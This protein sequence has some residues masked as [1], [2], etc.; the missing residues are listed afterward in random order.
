[1]SWPLTGTALSK[2]NRLLSDLRQYGDFPFV[3]SP[4]DIT[5]LQEVIIAASDGALRPPLDDV[6]NRSHFWMLEL[7]RVLGEKV[8]VCPDC[9]PVI[10]CPPCP[11]CP[12]PRFTTTPPG[13][14]AAFGVFNNND[15]LGLTGIVIHDTNI[16]DTGYFIVNQNSLISVSAPD[17]ITLDV[18]R[19][20]FNSHF[21]LT[22]ISLPVLTTADNGGG[23][24]AYFNPLLTSVSLPALATVDNASTVQVH[25]NA[26][27]TSFSLPALATVDNGANVQVYDN[28][29]LTMLSLGSV[30]FG[31]GSVLTFS[32]NALTD[33]SVNYILARCVANAAYVTGTV[34]LSGGTNA[35]PTG[36][37]IT[38]KAT[39]ITRGVIVTTN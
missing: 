14:E 10:P 39:L 18:A 13:L 36:Q 6:A 27:L 35:A 17:L 31:D 20:D 21:V 30:I 37:G 29:A 15:I 34:D 11:P 23:V 2:Y 12:E 33:V 28:A 7:A 24:L 16:T 9:P 4:D 3:G 22:S 1:M 26:A 32:G 8:V 5:W 38:D 25:D 19:I